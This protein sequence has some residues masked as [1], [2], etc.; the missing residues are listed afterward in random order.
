MS[1]HTLHLS[2]RRI[3]LVTESPILFKVC[4]VSKGYWALRVGFRVWAVGRRFACLLPQLLALLQL[5]Q[6]SK[7]GALVFR[8]SGT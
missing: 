6:R 2:S 4:S 3:Y 8:V 1:P 7:S 5:Q